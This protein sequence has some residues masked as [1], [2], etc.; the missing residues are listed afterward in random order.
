M[1]FSGGMHSQKYILIR[2]PLVMTIVK[3]KKKYTPQPSD[4]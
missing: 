1:V 2:Q 4:L 3:L